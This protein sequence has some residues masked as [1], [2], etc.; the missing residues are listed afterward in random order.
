[1]GFVRGDTRVVYRRRHSYRTASNKIKAV[2]T[3]GGRLVAQYLSK[4]AK[5]PQNP[6]AC[7]CGGALQGIPHLRSVEYSRLSKRQKSVNRAYGGNMC[8]SCVRDR[9]VR[10]FLIEEQ[11]VVKLVRK[12]QAKIKQPADEKPAE[13]PQQKKA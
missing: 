8:A 3:P 9:I 2:R 10:A 1:M 5:G 6:K 11:T 4:R 13:K 7:E 12:A